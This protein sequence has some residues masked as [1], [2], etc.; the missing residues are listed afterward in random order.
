[1][2]RAAGKVSLE[3]P[4]DGMPPSQLAA[5]EEVRRRILRGEL[6]PGQRLVEAELSELLDASRGTVRAALTA[7]AHE[8]LVERIANIGARVRVVT[9]E[10]ALQ[11]SEVRLAVESLC[12]AR[13]A[14]KITKAEIAELRAMLKTMKQ[15]V[16]SGDPAGFAESTHELFNSYVGIADQPVAEEMLM[17]LRARNSRHRFRLTF[18]PGRAAVALP[19]WVDLIEAICKRDPVAA[20]AALE[21]HV[22][23][24]QETM[25][26]IAQEDKPFA[27]DY[28]SKGLD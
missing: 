13:A 22:R 5:V 2:A 26:A 10:E 11:I 20:R 15:R 12:V 14:E 1:M 19:F 3:S 27:L 24:V 16:A 18:R 8:G 21:R 9:L 7:L 25:R 28:A 4:T 23:N 17:R 6:V